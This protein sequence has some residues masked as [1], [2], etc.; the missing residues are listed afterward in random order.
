MV[1]VKIDE[2]ALTGK[3]AEKQ[4]ADADPHGEKNLTRGLGKTFGV[5]SLV[6]GS[7]TRQYSMVTT[8]PSL[9]LVIQQ[10]HFDEF[11]RFQPAI[12]MSLLYSTKVFLLQRYSTLSSSIFYSFSEHEIEVAA[13]LARIEPVK[14]GETIYSIGDEPEA[15]YVLVHGS[16]HRDYCNG[17]E[18]QALTVGQYFGE[19]GVLLPNTH[20]FANVSAVE[21]STLLTISKVCGLPAA[22]APHH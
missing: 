16:L 19:V 3:R 7:P 15:F 5:A 17:S 14:A 22:L 18:P 8:E 20:C 2:Q 1:Q 9:F 11:L 13:K 12:E 10:D 21:N 6:L 4:T